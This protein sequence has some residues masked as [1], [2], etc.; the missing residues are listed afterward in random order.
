MI[1]KKNRW[2]VQSLILSV[3]LNLSF[4]GIFF[5][6]LIKSNPLHFS[7]E[8]KVEFKTEKLPLGHS[9][10]GKLKELS[11]NQLVELLYDKQVVEHGYRAR[12]FSVAALAAFYDFDILR[13][14]GK[15]QVSQRQWVFE[16]MT[17]TLYPDLTDSDFAA[18]VSFAEVERYP[19]TTKGL[20]NQIE[21]NDR[22]P[23]LLA[24]FCHTPEFLTLETL[25]SRTKLP[26]S[27][28][29]LLGMVREGGWERLNACY[30]KQKKQSDF[31]DAFRQELLLGYI[32]GGSKTAAY[33]LLLTDP[34]FAASR[35]E[36]RHVVQM[37]DLLDVKTQEA[38]LFVE[39]ILASPRREP[40][41]KRAF[42]RLSDFCG[43]EVA[44]RYVPRPGEGQLRPVFRESPPAAPL[45]ATHIVQEGESLWS[46]S[47]KYSVPIELLMEANQLQSTVIRPGKTLKI[48]IKHFN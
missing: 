26:L 22:D 41:R 48:P 47:R 29:T 4:V 23:D 32:E 27:K 35:L 37:L 1:S 10:L 14:L 33:L 3:V 24:Y 34:E 18:L 11:L 20:L 46:I 38:S 9:Y 17:F 6:F 2:L 16:E 12:D 43:D 42:Q 36:D 21:N 19:F 15:R 25:F 7:F 30:E 5:Y 40:V 8:P 28:G 44:G 13:A 45:P 39:K 31:S